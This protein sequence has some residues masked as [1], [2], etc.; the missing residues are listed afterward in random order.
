M[1]NVDTRSRVLAW[2]LSAASLLSFAGCKKNSKTDTSGHSSGDVVQESDPYYEIEEI[3][4]KVPMDESKEI[5]SSYY[6][7]VYFL[8]DRIM[9]SYEFSYKTA[10]GEEQEMLRRFDQGEREEY[11]AW[12]E[13]NNKHGQALFDLQGNLIS[14][15][16]NMDPNAGQLAKI[17]MNEAGE[18][19]A[20]SYQD[21]AVVLQKM[22]DDGS[23]EPGIQLAVDVASERDVMFLPNGNILVANWD[24]LYLLDSNGQKIASGNNDEFQGKLF[25]QDGKCYGSC[26]HVDENDFEKSTE[27]IQEINMQTCAFQGE[28]ILYPLCNSISK[29][30]NGNYR[31]NDNGIIKID[32]L[33][34]SK[35]QEV[36]SWNEADY[37]HNYVRR[38]QTMIASDSEFYFISIPEEILGDGINGPLQI[39]EQPKLVRAVRAEKNPHAGKKIIR[40]GTYRCGLPDSLKRYNL[41]DQARCRIEVHY[42]DEDQREMQGETNLAS[43]ATLSD[44]VYLDMISGN[45]P[46]V[47]IGFSG[48][49]QFNSDAVMVDLNPYIDATDGTGLNRSQYFD[50]IFRSAEVGDKLYHMPVLFSLSGYASNRELMGDQTSWTYR[51]FLDA[52]AKLSED[53]TVLKETPYDNL[54][55]SLYSTEG[56]SLVDY[57]N[58]DVHFDSEGFQQMLEV[59]KRYGTSKS[60]SE[61]SMAIDENTPDAAT[62]FR[63][64]L[65]AFINVAFGSLSGYATQVS[66]LGGKAVFCGLPNSTGGSMAAELQVTVGISKFSKYQNESWEIVKALMS[67]EEQIYL[68]DGTNKARMP[69]SRVALNQQNSTVRKANADYV[70]N[71]ADPEYDPFGTGTIVITEEYEAELVEIIEN[72]HCVTS[73]DP[74]VLSIIIEEAPGYFTDQRSIQDV[75]AIIQN[76]TRIIVQE[77]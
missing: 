50:N 48:F 25:L 8:G 20:V 52:T 10:P 44:K 63:E 15:T 75:C 4:L 56:G 38:N 34:Q 72:V 70:E 7:E 53:V 35:K 57:E 42:Y 43:N 54:L 13:A 1:K 67:E 11:Y 29:G 30:Q 59:V 21:N 69:V 9:M 65:L 6:E 31:V 22:N 68:S 74:S 73:N 17:F 40:V 27:Y 5:A 49:F 32:L 62:L 33:D 19:Y 16:E 37:D 45:G 61:I 39:V 51:E 47:L 26:Y 55:A 36:F 3:D 28:K 77:R 66:Q 24:G 58:K 60:Y 64:D 76:R 2:T 18:R 12:L 46:D 14:T 41:D 23:L 71:G